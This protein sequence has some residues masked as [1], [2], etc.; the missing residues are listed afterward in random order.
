VE[1]FSEGLTFFCNGEG[2]NKYKGVKIE[3]KSG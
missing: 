3:I 1:S 2:W